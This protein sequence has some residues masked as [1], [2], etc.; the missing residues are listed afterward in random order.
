MRQWLYRHLPDGVRSALRP[1]YYPARALSERLQLWRAWRTSRRAFF[2]AVSA[3]ALSTRAH[4][5]NRSRTAPAYRSIAD[6]P[7]FQPTPPKTIG[8]NPLIHLVIPKNPPLFAAQLDNVGVYA[9][10]GD[11]VKDNVLLADLSFRT[12]VRLRH[13][14]DEHP[15]LAQNRLPPAVPLRGTYALLTSLYGGT[16]YFH[17]MFNVLPRLALFERAGVDPAQ[18]AGYLVNRLTLPAARESLRLLNISD[19]HCIEM[20]RVSAFRVE[21]LWV[22]PSLITSGHRRR[23]ICAWLRQHFLR[24]TPKPSRRLYLSRADASMRRIANETEMLEL[25]EPLGFEKIVI[26]ASSVL[27]QAELFAQAQVVIA[28]HS[29]SLTNLV[30]CSPGTRVLDLM[31]ED[32]LRTYYWELSACMGLDYYYACTKPDPQPLPRRVRMYDSIMPASDLRTML[33]R[34][35]I[36]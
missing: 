15:L 16:N 36:A 3:Y 22:A 11:V 17:L 23:S 29:A 26:G 25:L 4:L 31:P 7:A 10:A 24:S 33:N 28:P 12:P 8:Y 34:M 6:E 32:R 9:D 35:S 21:H 27:E 5:L 20:D 18:L 30:F 1:L 14:R 19:S 13:E 2:P